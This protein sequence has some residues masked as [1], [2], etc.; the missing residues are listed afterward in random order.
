MSQED[1][2]TTSVTKSRAPLAKFV[3]QWVPVIATGVAFFMIVLDTSIV[4]LALA[5]I[6]TEFNSGLV[7]FAVAGRRLRA[8][9][10]ELVIGGRG[11]R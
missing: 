4:N 1:R 6:R 2:S 7:T 8:G 3:A 5:R 10:C 11:A 9:F